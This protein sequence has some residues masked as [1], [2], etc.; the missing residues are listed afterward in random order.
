[1][2][3]IR[4]IDEI[5]LKIIRNIIDTFLKKRDFMREFLA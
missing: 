4:N 2:R 5:F 1:M 3:S